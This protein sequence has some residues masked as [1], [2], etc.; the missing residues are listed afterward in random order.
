MLFA[1]LYVSSQ[2]GSS[3]LLKSCT[4]SP[5]HF[6]IYSSVMLNIFQVLAFA[7]APLTSEYLLECYL[8]LPLTLWPQLCVINSVNLHV[9]LHVSSHPGN[10]YWPTTSVVPSIGPSLHCILIM[11]RVVI[12]SPAGLWT[13][14]EQKILSILFSV[15]L[16]VGAKYLFF[17]LMNW[18]DQWMN[19]QIFFYS[20]ML[21]LPVS[22]QVT[23]TIFSNVLAH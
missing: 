17:W 22:F 11:F 2:S 19:G 12:L 6:G 8:L 20:N 16:I 14:W 1:S 23:L 18:K 7:P 15:W 3:F 10:L 5:S 21:F 13:M 9:S 4:L